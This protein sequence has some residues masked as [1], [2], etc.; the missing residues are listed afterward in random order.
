MSLIVRIDVDRP[1]GKEGFIRHVASRI[2]SDY[3]LPRMS[4]LRYL[5]ELET[6]LTLL[7]EQ[8]MPAWVFFRKCTLPTDKVRALMDAGHH[9]YGLHLENSRSEQ[10]FRE[11]L[12]SLERTLGVS[13]ESFSKHGSGR[14]KYGWNHYAPYEPEKYRVWAKQAGLKLFMGN[15]EDPRLLPFNDNGLLCYPSAFWLEPHWRDANQFSVD[16]LLR[17]AQTRDVVMLIHP[18][19]VTSDPEIL[20]NFRLIIESLKHATLALK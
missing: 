3:V 20:R 15:L 8:Q 2:A 13:I 17:E 14:Y 1:Y 18:D 16:W 5:E 7:N 4:S 6:I 12:A 10:T 11:E 9:H 19:N